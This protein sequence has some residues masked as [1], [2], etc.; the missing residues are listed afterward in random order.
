M[1]RESKQIVP[2]SK[3]RKS[4]II[5]Y[6]ICLFPFSQQ[7]NATFDMTHAQED[8]NPPLKTHYETA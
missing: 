3:R 1:E 6:L 7:Q 4:R 8:T 5:K 2:N